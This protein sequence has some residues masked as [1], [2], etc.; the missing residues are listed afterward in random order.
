MKKTEIVYKVVRQNNQSG[1]FQSV[2]VPSKCIFGREYIIG[3]RI[4][5]EIGYL[6][7][8]HT[9]QDAIEFSCNTRYEYNTTV[10][11]LECRAVVC[12]PKL[13]RIQ[14]LRGYKS[15]TIAIRAF[16]KNTEADLPVG[17]NVP[18][19]TVFCKFITPK[20]LT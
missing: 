6:F 9:L 16:W 17:W 10:K 7:A 4:Y 5:P 11:V 19:G 1:K 3:K 20:S 14:N 13:V 8:F 12:S 2:M 15:F 18:R